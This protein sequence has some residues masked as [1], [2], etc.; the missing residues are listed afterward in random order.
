MLMFAGTH[1]ESP[2]MYFIAKTNRF[3]AANV[4][5]ALSLRA[6]ARLSMCTYTNGTPT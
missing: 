1:A 6:T 5:D 3:D 2:Y 4:V